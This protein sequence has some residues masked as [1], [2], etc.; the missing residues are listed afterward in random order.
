[1]LKKMVKKADNFMGKAARRAYFEC[2]CDSVITR[3]LDKVSDAICMF[4]IRF[5]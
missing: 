1:M 2:G 5:C 4:S 3:V